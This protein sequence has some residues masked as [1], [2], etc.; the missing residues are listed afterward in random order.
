MPG[1]RRGGVRRSGQLLPCVRPRPPARPVRHRSPAAAA[2]GG[3]ADRGR[4]PGAAARGTQRPA[5]TSPGPVHALVAATLAANALYG[6]AWGVLGVALSAWPG[7]AF[8]GSVELLMG[9]VRRTRSAPPEP[10]ASVPRA[11]PERV[12]AAARRGRAVRR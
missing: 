7:A 12:R 1:H 8:V 10:G 3:R 5:S 9:I 11:A 6:L 2:V 4:V